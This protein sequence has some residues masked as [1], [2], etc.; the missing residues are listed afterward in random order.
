MLNCIIIIIITIIESIIHKNSLSLSLPSLSS[1][2]LLVIIALSLYLCVT[3]CLSGM[4]K[5]T[6]VVMLSN[7]CVFITV[8]MRE[9]GREACTMYVC[10]VYSLHTLKEKSS[11]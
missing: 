10:Y 6:G 5:V 9:G 1:L 11:G 8:S 3:V 7:L 2:S 4:R